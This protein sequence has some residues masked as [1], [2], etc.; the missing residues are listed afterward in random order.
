MPKLDTVTSMVAGT[1]EVVGL[2]LAIHSFAQLRPDLFLYA[3]VTDDPNQHWALLPYTAGFAS[4]AAVLL[5]NAALFD[6]WHPLVRGHGSGVS[7][8]V[9]V[10]VTFLKIASVLAVAAWATPSVLISIFFSTAVLQNSSSH[11]DL[12][13]IA[14][15]QCRRMSSVAVEACATFVLV[16]VCIAAHCCG[17]CRFCPTFSGSSSRGRVK[18]TDGMIKS[19][20][21]PLKNF[22]WLWAL[23]LGLAA[24][25][26]QLLLA[27]MATGTGA[28]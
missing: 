3:N 24:M 21:G 12:C 16:V 28:F 9:S 11:V 1:L 4:G 23:T 5:G 2:V 25:V 18:F 15:S 13:S 19:S 20:T 14:D 26:T 17:S 7:K 27:W 6:L 8:F 10:P 22:G